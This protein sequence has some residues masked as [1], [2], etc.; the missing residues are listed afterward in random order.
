[1]LKVEGA[2]PDAPPIEI[3]DEEPTAAQKK[4]KKKKLKCKKSKA[5]GPESKY[6]MFRATIEGIDKTFV[7]QKRSKNP[8][9]FINKKTH[10][11]EILPGLPYMST[12]SVDVFEIRNAIGD[13]TAM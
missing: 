1:M 12:S 6:K 8:Y 2:D 13:A 10:K 4:K 7:G 9:D 3:I 11:I 5:T